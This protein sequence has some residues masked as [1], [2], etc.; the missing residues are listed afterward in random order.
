[1]KKFG[2]ILLLLASTSAFAF[3]GGGGGQ[4]RTHKWY[5]HGVDSIGVHVGGDTCTDDQELIDGKCLTKCGEGLERNTD[6]TCTVCTNGNV[7]L[8][9]MD[10]PC[11][12]LTPMNEA[13]QAETYCHCA[14]A[15]GKCVSDEH[16]G[17][18][19]SSICAAS[20]ATPCKSNKD[21]AST[22]YCSLTNSQGGCL[23]PDVGTCMSLTEGVSY[24]YNNKTFLRSDNRMSSWWAAE[25]WCKAKGMT[26]VSLASIGMDNLGDFFNNN[27]YCYGDDESKC[28]NV[29]WNA[30][31]SAFPDIYENYRNWWIRDY[32]YSSCVAFFVSLFG[33]AVDLDGRNNTYSYALCE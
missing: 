4:G 13:T 16:N 1:M 11:G 7:Y 19:G 5:R 33:A 25:N 26:L 28:E 2:L 23:Q 3:G 20:D 14:N 17:E 31:R 15:D 12:T 24:T 21:C 18:N 32:S 6:D 9:Y 10:D 30:I 29:D 27:K 22:E 8:S